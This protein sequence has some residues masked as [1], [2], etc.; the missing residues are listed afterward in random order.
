MPLIL[1]SKPKKRQG[2]I[3][4]KPQRPSGIIEARLRRELDREIRLMLAEVQP[5]AN[6]DISP[7]EKYSKLWAAMNRWEKRF[8]GLGDKEG[9]EL[10]TKTFDRNKQQLIDQ[11][12]DKLKVNVDVMWDNKKFQTMMDES[13]AV[14]TN[15]I[16]SIPAKYF[17]E[18]SQ[19]IINE[20]Q[21]TGQPG[22]VTLWQQIQHVGSVSRSRAILIARDQTSKANSA[23][24]E[25]QFEQADLPVYIWTTSRDS[26]VVGKPGGLYPKGS[27]LHHDHYHRDGKMYFWKEPTA[28]MKKKYPKALPPPAGGPPGKE[29]QCRCISIPVMDT[30][31]L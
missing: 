5:I 21:K 25:Y 2:L 20:M 15:L 9:S 29:I 16:R 6:S 18:V 12:A 4:L 23:I 11:L 10:F 13:I 28:A 7:K 3:R 14:S 31:A 8:E 1:I 22:G 26:R 27:A 30:S 17:G 19:A 24:S